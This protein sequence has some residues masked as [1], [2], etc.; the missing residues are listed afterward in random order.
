MIRN[1]AVFVVAMI[2]PLVLFVGCGLQRGFDPAPQVSTGESPTLSPALASVGPGQRLQLKIPDH[3]SGSLWVWCVDGIPGG[4]P[5]LGVI[6]QN[7]LFQ[8]PWQSD[9]AVTRTITAYALEAP[10]NAVVT[11]RVSLTPVP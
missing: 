5:E 7:G 2:I 10:E 8:A 9:G 1:A 6:D 4:D 11:G 3:V